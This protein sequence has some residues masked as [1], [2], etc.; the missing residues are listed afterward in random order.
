MSGRSRAIVPRG[1]ERQL[2]QLA[3]MFDAPAPA[4][5]TP[6]AHTDKDHTAQMVLSRAIATLRGRP[7]WDLAYLA[8]CELIRTERAR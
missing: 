2:E 1:R 8:Q 4:P 5:D 7:L 3:A 6:P